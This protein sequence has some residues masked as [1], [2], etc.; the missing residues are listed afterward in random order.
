MVRFCARDAI[1]APSHCSVSTH[2]RKR[3]PTIAGPVRGV[4][5]PIDAGTVL[6]TVG[7]SGNARGTPPHLHCGSDRFRGGAVNPFVYLR[8]PTPEAFGA[9]MRA[10][11]DPT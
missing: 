4:K 8:N 7:D 11:F 9:M 6:G 2:R 1:I 10:V 3:A 5:R